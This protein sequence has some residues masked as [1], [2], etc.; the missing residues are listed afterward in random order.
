[1]KVAVL[2]QGDPRFC[3][4]FDY[5]LD[6]ITEFD[7]V[8]WFFHM[9]E[10]SSE[11]SNIVGSG[12]H[13]IIAPFWQNINKEQ[14]IEKIKANLPDNHQIISLELEDQNIVNHHPITENY[15]RETVQ[16]NVWK[17]WYSL[18]KVN[19]ARLEH[20][21]KNNFTYDLI[22]R[23][24]PDV[25]LIEK[26]NLREI[27]K[28]LESIKTKTI[29]I[30]SNRCCGYGVRFCD[31]FAIGLSE[32]MNI[33]CDIYNQALSQHQRGTIF[34]PETILAKY[35]QHSGVSYLQPFW[36]LKIEFRWLGVWKNINTQQEFSSAQVPTWKDH[37]YISNFG[38]WS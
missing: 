20:E 21:I 14:A 32:E 4:E 30:P 25:A 2:I 16:P 3:K 36:K 9:W 6:N 13:S 27:K 37:I 28:H 38:R 35:L 23:T 19:Q 8:H 11:T 17:M 31:L 15:A 24:R 29:I 18:Y 1:M 12:G 33:Y 5:F 10:K 34:H 26:I 22:I 7:E